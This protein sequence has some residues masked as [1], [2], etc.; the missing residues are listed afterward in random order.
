MTIYDQIRALPDADFRDL[1]NWIITEETTRRAQEPAVR[2]GQ[3]EI[4]TGLQADGKLP[5]PEYTDAGSVEDV[6]AVPEWASPGT[7]HAKMYPSGAVVRHNDRVWESRADLNHWEPGAPGVDGRIWADITP[8]PIDEE[9]GEP[10]IIAWGVGQEVH[11]GDLRTHDGQ[12]WRA[13]IGHM[14]HAGWPPSPATHA[15]WEPV[16][17]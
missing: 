7:D 15:V 12:T 3:Q 1:K 16:N 5:K 11:P 2:A 8:V 14:T 13:K 10:Q 6:D 17:P 4:I 9:T